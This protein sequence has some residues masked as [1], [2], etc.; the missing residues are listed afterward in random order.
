MLIKSE[1][2][3]LARHT[4]RVGF[5]QDFSDTSG[6]LASYIRASDEHEGFDLDGSGVK[7][8]VVW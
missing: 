8:F 5:Q 4:N 1:S 2:L 7:F 3:F 6:D